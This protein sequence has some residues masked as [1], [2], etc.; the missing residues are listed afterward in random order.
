MTQP[1][2]PASLRAAPTPATHPRLAY[3]LDGLR[4]RGK[5]RAPRHAHPL[6]RAIFVAAN[7]QDATLAEIAAQAGLRRGAISDWGRVHHPRIDQLDAALNVLGLRLAVVPMETQ[8]TK[9]RG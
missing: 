1:S 8:E 4:W 5:L 6:V 9:G 7:R 3:R 2:V